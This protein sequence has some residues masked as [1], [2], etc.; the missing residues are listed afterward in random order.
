MQAHTHSLPC[1]Q[2]LVTVNENSNITEEGEIHQGCVCVCV[3]VRRKRDKK[4]KAGTP[5]TGMFCGLANDIAAT[6]TAVLH[7]Y[8][9]IMLTL[10]QRKV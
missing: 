5:N 2:H 1:T 4:K 8:N 7:T 9:V 3:C 6:T 10:Y